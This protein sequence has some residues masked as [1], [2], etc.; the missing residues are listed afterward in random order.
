MALLIN[1][2]LKAKGVKANIDVFSPQP[3]S[4]PILGQWVA[5]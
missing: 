1:D 4:L 2:K 3:M 5:I